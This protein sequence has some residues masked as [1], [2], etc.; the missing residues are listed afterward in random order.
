M[1]WRE[2]S[3]LPGFGLSFAILT[4]ALLALVLAPLAALIVKAAGA[5]FSEIVAIATSP[6]TLAALRLSF[7]A[8]AIAAASSSHGRSCVTT[9]P[10][11][12]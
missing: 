6:R 2:H 12:A 5:G 10:A 4:T 1:K 8:A 3:I 7:G 11:A 9:S